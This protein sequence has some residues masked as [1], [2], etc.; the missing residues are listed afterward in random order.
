V[1]GSGTRNGGNSGN[2][3]IQT[4]NFGTGSTSSGSAGTITFGIA[5]TAKMTISSSGFVGIGVTS[6]VNALDVGGNIS[7]S[8][9]TA[10]IVGTDTGNSNLSLITSGSTRV[11]ISSSG[12][13]G[14]GTI[15][16]GT[17][18]SLGVTTENTVG[19]TIAVYESAG[20]TIYGMGLCRSGSYGLGLYASSAVGTPRVYIQTTGN[21]GIGTKLP[22]NA[23]DVVGNISCSVIT[24]SLFNGGINMPIIQAGSASVS[25]AT[26][27]IFTFATAMP[28]TNY[29]E[30]LSTNGAVSNLAWSNKT[31]N[32]FTSSMLAFTGLIDFVVVGT[33]Q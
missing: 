7:C 13:V 5:N 4:G 32:G 27:N 1:S 19:S 23:L 11:Y 21:V 25:T 26:S 24:A 17:K 16:P 2:I 10:S 30:A 6:P 15:V 18:V 12:N 14:V 29:S 22:A 33:T 3:T 8:V 20:A 31:I 9:I 28:S